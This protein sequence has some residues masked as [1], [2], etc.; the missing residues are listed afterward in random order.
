MGRRFGAPWCVVRR[1]ERSKLSLRIQLAAGMVVWDNGPMS[2]STLCSSRPVG[3]SGQVYAF[4]PM[5][6]ISRTFALTS[7]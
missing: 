2:A 1:S 7:S 5:R 3:R 4:E 6:K